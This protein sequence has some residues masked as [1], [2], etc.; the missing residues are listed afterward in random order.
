MSFLGQP[1]LRSHMFPV[2][3][4]Q[5][6]FFHSAVCSDLKKHENSVLTCFAQFNSNL[7]NKDLPCPLCYIIPIEKHVFLGSKCLLNYDCSS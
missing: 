7:E 3:Q 6:M 2:K 5:S 1:E 4:M